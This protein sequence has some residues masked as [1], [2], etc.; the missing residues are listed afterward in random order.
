M[1]NLTQKTC[2]LLQ[3]RIPAPLEVPTFPENSLTTVC[4]DGNVLYLNQAG[5]GSLFAPLIL[6]TYR[7]LNNMEEYIKKRK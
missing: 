1:S 6:P 7:H 3:P 4:E 5:D 2:F